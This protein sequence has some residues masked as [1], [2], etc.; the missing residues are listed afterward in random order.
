MKHPN[1]GK[2]EWLKQLSEIAHGTRGSDKEYNEHMAL[3]LEWWYNYGDR[4][5]AL[6]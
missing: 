6:H 2:R 3:S 1:I 4:H 5:K